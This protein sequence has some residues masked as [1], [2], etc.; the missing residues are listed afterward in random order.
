MKQGQASSSK[1]GST[2]V[3]PRSRGV[4][5]GAVSDIGIVEL[6]TKPVQMYVGRGI[7]APKS[8]DTTYECGSQGRY[9]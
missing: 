3:E 8:K 1:S 2:K 5:P 9:K 4:N 7:E 6:R